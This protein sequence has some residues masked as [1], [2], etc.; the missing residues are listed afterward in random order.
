MSSEEHRR[1]CQLTRSSR[2]HLKYLCQKVLL[3]DNFTPLDPAAEAEH[4]R[5]LIEIIKS[6]K[7][8]VLEE[9]LFAFIWRTQYAS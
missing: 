2:L 3:E 6:K 9:F 1:L 8:K 7:D 5:I 4:T